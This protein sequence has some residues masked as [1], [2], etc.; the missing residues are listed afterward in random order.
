[1][2]RQIE[3]ARGFRQLL[4]PGFEKVQDESSLVCTTHNILTPDRLCV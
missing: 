4:L 3:H 2:I 1:V